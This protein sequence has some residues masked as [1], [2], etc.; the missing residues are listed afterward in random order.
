MKKPFHVVSMLPSLLIASTVI[1]AAGDSSV[2]ELSD[3]GESVRE[4]LQEQKDVQGKPVRPDRP[5]HPVKPPKPPRPDNPNQP[6]KPPQPPQPPPPQPPKPVD[7]THAYNAGVRDG[8]ANGEREGRREG[9]SEGV[10]DGER[11]GRRNGINDG[12]RNGRQAG[13]NDGYTVDQSAGTHQGNSDGRNAGI[14]NGTAAGERRCYDE[15]YS[16]GYNSAYAEARQLG[17]QDAASYSSGYSKG[18][19]DA[20]VMETESGRKAGYQAGFS[21]R[22]NELQTSFPDMIA[23]A[24]GMDKDLARGFIDLPIDLARNGYTTPEERQAYER[25]YREGYQRSYRRAYD[26]AKRQGYNERYHNAY[27]RAYENQYSISYR[28]GYIDGK[29]EGYKAAYRTAYNSAYAMAYAE[30]SNREYADK[31]A[32]GLENG[33]ATGRAEGFEAGCAEQ[34]KRGYNE[35]YQ[36]KAAEV[37]PAAFEAGKLSGIAAAERFYAEN[38]VVRVFGAA[39]YDENNNGRFEAGENVMLRAELRNFG[40][41]PS[42]T[43]AIT[44]R[45]ERGEITLVPDLHAQGVGGRSSAVVDLNIGRIYDIAAPEQDALTVTFTEKGRQIGD[46][47]QLYVRTNPNRVAVI[48]KDDTAIK[49]KAGW[50]FVGTVTKLNAGEKVLITGEKDDWYKVR[51]SEFGSGS[52]TEG[53]VKKGKVSLQ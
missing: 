46:H 19:A 34:R 50:L 21:Q 30:Y 29:D 13:Y 47:R 2:K 53:F 12:E 35:G 39:F 49:E 3:V 10:N 18:Q 33:R 9:Y 40:M 1:L 20:S 15:G 51:R 11:E 45:S 8:S 41:R 26:D 24:R 48:N 17:L 14:S 52:W 25:G 6:P 43:V 37:Y 31:R 22:E 28:N 36:E 7:T 16:N 4:M 32:Q 38:A 44:V 27:R 23:M 5:D 42:E